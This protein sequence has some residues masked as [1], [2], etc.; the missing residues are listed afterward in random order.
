[1]GEQEVRWDKG[2]NLRVGDYTFF[3]GKVNENHQSG[4]GFFFVQHRILPVVKKVE[5]VSD[6]MSYTALRCRW[7]NITVLKRMHQVKRKVTIQKTVFMRN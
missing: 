6:R 2:G 7:C 1:V 3:N 5:F 4:T